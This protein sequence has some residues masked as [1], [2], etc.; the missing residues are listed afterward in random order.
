MTENTHQELP[1]LATRRQVAEFTQTS[2]STLA[3]W[4][5]D[6]KGPK[7]IRLGGSAGSGGAVRYR[8]ADVLAWINE[9]GEGA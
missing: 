2:V 7:F 6:G 4:A 1:E 3:R 5:M 8:R 9:L